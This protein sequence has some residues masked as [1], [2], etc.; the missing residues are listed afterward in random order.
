MKTIGRADH[1][2]LKPLTTNDVYSRF[3]SVLSVGQIT[4]IGN[5]VSVT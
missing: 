4:V 3:K 2:N 5:E 1:L